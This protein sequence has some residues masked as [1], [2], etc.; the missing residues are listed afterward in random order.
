[1]VGEALKV[2]IAYVVIMF[3]DVYLLNWQC[4]NRPI[5]TGA[6][7]GLILGDLKTGL[8]MGAYLESI[9]M[10]ISTIGASMPSDPTSATIITVAFAIL[11]GENPEAGMAL[12]VPIGTLMA[13]LGGLTRPIFGA[14]APYWEKLA[15]QAKPK[16]L[17]TQ[18]LILS[19][20]SLALVGGMIIFF[21]VAYGIDGFNALLSALPAWVMTGLSAGST[22]MIG[23]GISI[24]TSMIW[25]PKVGVFFFLGFVLAKSLGLS[26]LA[27]A[28][29][30][31]VIAVAIFMQDKDLI[32]LKNSIGKKSQSS[33]EGGFF[34]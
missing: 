32:D 6:I 12:A 15:G 31:I 23:V 30:G 26:T 19:F 24:L 16:Q 1:M 21:A 25:S 11:S 9:F 8:I 5:V 4:F 28:I 34:A 33:K 18:T 7:V 10:G 17:L 27:I 20:V 13:S 2:A 29:L 22:M 14:L 3:V